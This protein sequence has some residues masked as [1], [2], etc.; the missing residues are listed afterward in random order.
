MTESGAIACPVAGKSMGRKSRSIIPIDDLPSRIVPSQGEPKYKPKSEIFNRLTREAA[1]A[2]KIAS[3]SKEEARQAHVEENAYAEPFTYWDW[4]GL[5]KKES[6][7][8]Q[9]CFSF[10]EGDGDL[11]KRRLLWERERGCKARG[12]WHGYPSEKE[13]W[14]AFRAAI[15]ATPAN[16]AYVKSI[17]VSHWMT[18]DD[19]KWIADSFPNLTRLDLSHLQH[20]IGFENR[21]PDWKLMAR[22]L[23]ES[24]HQVLKRLNWLACSSLQTLSI[25]G[26]YN[27]G[28]DL[29]CDLHKSVCGLILGLSENLPETVRH[30]EARMSLPLLRFTLEELQNRTSVKTVG[31]DL[32]AWIQMYPL[33]IR[34]NVSD[35]DKKSRETQSAYSAS[36]YQSTAGFRLGPRSPTKS[37]PRHPGCSIDTSS[38][39][40]YIEYLLQQSRAD[41]LGQMLGNL[42]D[43]RPSRKLK[44]KIVPITPEPQVG[45]TDPI[46]PLAFIQSPHEIAS[47]IWE[48]GS[49]TSSLSRNLKEVYDWLS[50]EFSWRPI[51]DWDWLMLPEE[52]ESTLD[53]AYSR[54]LLENE[55]YL[56]RI[57]NQFQ[58]LREAHIPVHL[59][60]GRRDL[61]GSSL[62][63]GWPYNEGKWKQWLNKRFDTNLSLI[64]GQIDSLSIFYDL[65]NPLSKE[66]LEEIDQVQSYE[67]PPATCPFAHCPWLNKGDDC[68]F[69]LQRLPQKHPKRTYSYATQQKM[70]NKHIL[71]PRDGIPKSY[72]GLANACSAS[73]PHVGE[74]A[75]DHPS[76]DSDS[77]DA[78]PVDYAKLQHLARRAAYTR[79]AVG[80]QRFWAEYALKLTRLTCLRVRM[81]RCFDKIGSWRLA[82]LLNTN[83]GWEMLMYTDERQH[84]QTQED[85]VRFISHAKPEEFE[86]EPEDKVWPA[87]RF[88]RRSWIWPKRRVV[89][90]DHGVKENGKRNV[91]MFSEAVPEWGDRIFTQKDY[92]DTEAGENIE[93]KKARLAAELAAV[94]EKQLEDKLHV[95]RQQHKVQ[96]EREKE[97]SGQSIEFE[98]PTPEELDGQIARVKE[99]IADLEQREDDYQPSILTNTPDPFIVS[100]HEKRKE[101]E[102]ALQWLQYRLHEI[103]CSSGQVAS[104]IERESLADELS[105]FL[106]AR[107]TGGL[108]AEAEPAVNLEAQPAAEHPLT[109]IIREE[110]GQNLQFELGQ[111]YPKFAI[112]I[113]SFSTPSGLD[114]SII[115]PS[116]SA[117]KRKRGDGEDDG[118]SAARTKMSRSSTI[119]V[120]G[121]GVEV[122][123]TPDT[124]T[125]TTVGMVTRGLSEIPHSRMAEAALTLELEEDL[126]RSPEPEPTAT[127]TEIPLSPPIAQ[128]SPS[129]PPQS[130]KMKITTAP[131]KRK[132]PSTKSIPTT[133]LERPKKTTNRTKTDDRKYIDGS[134]PSDD[135]PSLSEFE[136]EE[137]RKKKRTK[138]SNDSK[139]VQPKLLTLDEEEQ[140]GIEK[141]RKGNPER[142]TKR[143]HRGGKRTGTTRDK[144]K[145]NDVEGEIS[146]KQGESTAEKE[147]KKPGRKKAM[148]LKEELKSPVAG[149][150]RSRMKKA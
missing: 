114:Q 69:V 110:A 14:N 86:H 108:P 150:T 51:F 37:Q 76:D 144:K 92:M 126:E 54:E 137:P 29:Y 75:N 16:Q 149:R 62:Y 72:K 120:G 147:K 94:R 56:A 31:L 59:L 134:P 140:E 26:E 135:D 43:A 27:L 49:Q 104:P 4:H 64:A 106:H 90:H 87:G 65:R 17:A 57:E 139:Y 107:V 127:P 23:E 105:E 74:N 53:T 46:H 32:G 15:D 81:P 70:A 47:S 109:R 88:V 112:P 35:P 6:A 18:L 129:P 2:Y 67:R 83:F 91:E 3:G 146:V 148:P 77:G 97:R 138:K 61:H 82:N 93:V 52:M 102:T 68:P 5:S 96:M 19:I 119:R 40:E 118:V 11:K 60:I 1:A 38:N 7:G 24:K 95:A 78:G 103:R 73:S 36:Y 99:D 116:A 21:M 123:K 80:W 33:R 13:R 9:E 41:T 117:E 84:I 142:G 121:V 48:V 12:K 25:R 89:F 130:I 66:R 143:G 101:K 10:W 63:W 50:E 100:L 55:Q 136:P 124:K 39:H 44:V 132:N 22:T 28:H 45:S 30:I 34:D 85:L 20:C 133:E 145:V 79:E 131:A 115:S 122:T 58:C 128:P 98:Q 42:Y 111:I 8:S 113:E 141:R 125:T 71:R